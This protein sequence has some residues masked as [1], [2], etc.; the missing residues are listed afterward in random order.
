MSKLSNCERDNLKYL[1]HME[2][3]GLGIRVVETK[4]LTY[5]PKQGRHL[6]VAKEELQKLEVDQ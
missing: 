3:Y 4:F 5:Q 2:A 6:R 1:V